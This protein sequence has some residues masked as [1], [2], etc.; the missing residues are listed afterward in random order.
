[1]ENIICYCFSHTAKDLEDDVIKNGKSTIKEKIASEKK[2]G[3][4]ECKTKNPK[5]M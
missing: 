1:M 5:G 3:G 2:T 4:C